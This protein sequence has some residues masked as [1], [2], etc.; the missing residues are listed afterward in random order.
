MSVRR[1][2][3]QDERETLQASRE[4]AAKAELMSHLVK[5]ARANAKSI[6]RPTLRPHTAATLTSSKV[7]GGPPPPVRGGPSSSGPLL[8]P[9][10][11]AN[12]EVARQRADVLLA[13][14]EGANKKADAMDLEEE[15][16]QQQQQQQQQDISNHK[17]TKM[18]LSIMKETS[19]PITRCSLA[20]LDHRLSCAITTTTTTKKKK[21]LSAPAAIPPFGKHRRRQEAKLK[22]LATPSFKQPPMGFGGAR[23]K[24]SVSKIVSSRQSS[25]K[26][27]VGNA[28][29]SHAKLLNHPGNRRA[30]M[31]FRHKG[32][33]SE[34]ESFRLFRVNRGFKSLVGV[35]DTTSF[36][37]RH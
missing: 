16:Q 8:P 30:H 3:T 22:E 29:V 36:A 24:F 23:K 12:L 25:W 6:K 4:R 28:E 13:K 11:R 35:S 19:K 2:L 31:T 20:S 5:A 18:M 34:Y 33:A 32:A 17:K 26:S 7:H 1:T 9:Q 27:L 37:S 10:M 14:F 21:A 15:G